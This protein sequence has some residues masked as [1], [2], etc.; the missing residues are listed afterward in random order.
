MQISPGAEPRTLSPFVPGNGDAPA[1]DVPSHWFLFREGKLLVAGAADEFSPPVA[2]PF[3]AGP[4]ALGLHP[5]R[6]HLLGT[7]A[8][9]PCLAAEVPAADPV[10][11]GWTFLALRA[12]FSAV[13]EELFRIAGRAT[14]VLDWDRTH[15][16]CGACGAPTVDKPGE[17]ARVCPACDLV[18][19]PRISPAVIVAVLRE[20]EILLARASRFVEGMYSVLAGFV[21]PGETLEECVHREVREET[22]IEVADVRYFG[23]QPWPFP[24]SLMVGFTARYAAGEI[25]LDQAELVDAGWYRADALPR[26]PHPLS[27]AR[28]LI[29]WFVE[30]RHG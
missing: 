28:R 8:G 27:I 24:N 22:G 11:A 4:A 6:V 29:D 5:R 21:E 14:Q 19:Y 3:A 25:V 30:S 20:D 9:S 7:A 16:F 15:R 23:S 10:P 1:G 12:L 26:V 2:V 13:G 17:R 18:S